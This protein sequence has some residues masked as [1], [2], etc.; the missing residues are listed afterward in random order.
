[1]LQAVLGSNFKSVAGLYVLNVTAV[2]S[3]ILLVAVLAPAT[4][5]A[6]WTVALSVL[7]F[8]AQVAL[9]GMTARKTNLILLVNG[10]VDWPALI[11]RLLLFTHA[12]WNE[13]ALLPYRS[14]SDVVVAAVRSLLSSHAPFANEQDIF[15]HLCI[16]IDEDVDEMKYGAMAAFE[17]FLP[18]DVAQFESMAEAQVDSELRNLGI[19]PRPVVDAVFAMPY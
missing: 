4:H 6:V 13:E 17:S 10:A 19:D 11:A 15:R 3:V 1:L 2:G 5:L 8:V 14:L 9:C 12:R 7:L 18:E 16:S